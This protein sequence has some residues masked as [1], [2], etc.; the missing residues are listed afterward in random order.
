MLANKLQAAVAGGSQEEEVEWNLNKA[1]LNDSN[2]FDLY[3]AS[4]TVDDVA[5]GAAE[6]GPTGVSFKPDGT[7]MFIIGGGRDAVCQYELTTAWDVSTSIFKKASSI[8]NS[9]PSTEG[10]GQGIFFKPDGTKLYIAGNTTDTIIEYDLSVAWDIGDISYNQA[11]SI[12]S[13]DSA[14]TDLFFKPDGTWM[15]ILGATLPDSV[16]AYQLSTPWDIST[17]VFNHDFPVNSQETAPTGLFFKSDGTQMYVT[18]SSGDDINIYNL[19]TPWVVSGATFQT[20]FSVSSEETAPSGLFISSDGLKMYVVGGAG[21]EVN[22]YTLGS[23]WDVTTAT[24]IQFFSATSPE[25]IATGCCFSSDGTRF[26]MV[27]QSLKSVWEY[28]LDTPWVI[29]GG[30]IELEKISYIGDEDELPE[31]ICFSSDGTQMY[32]LGRQNGRINQYS[33]STAWDINT[34]TYVDYLSIVSYESAA[35]GLYLSQDGHRMYFIGAQRKVFEFYLITAWDITS[36]V[37]TRSKDV[38]G[39]ESTPTA[40]TF[41]NDGTKFYTTGTT[42]DNIYEYN[43][44]DPWNITTASTGS[45]KSAPSNSPQSIFFDKDGVYLYT[46]DEV[47]RVYQYV[48]AGFQDTSLLSSCESVV[49]KSDGTK[50]FILDSVNDYIYQYNLSSAWDPSIYSTTFNQ[51]FNV[52][53]V[54]TSPRGFFISEDGTKMYI[55]GSSNDNVDFYTLSTPWDISTNSQVASFSVSAQATSPR[56]V[57]FKPDGTMMYVV[58]SGSL[59]VYQYS[60]ATAWTSGPSYESSF[61][62]SSEMST[63]VPSGLFIRS[64]GTQMYITDFDKNGSVVKYTLSSPWDITTAAYSDTYTFLRFQLTQIFFKPDGDGFFLSDDRYDRIFSYQIS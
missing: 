25:T 21:D 15:Y 5:V 26:F 7:V 27:G 19:D 4:T 55:T 54:D 36:A 41:N 44:S 45:A 58:D 62:L 31:E 20:T 49:F 35:R 47:P 29:V 42:D 33:L 32:I 64:D 23:S 17:A 39:Q 18:G 24:F 51:S 48:V 34:K 50:M 11:F 3:N 56:E 8:L 63:G 59:A 52:S 53:S 43:M 57:F 40:I 60:L 46:L 10:S 38:S 22:E 37:S 30:G 9:G 1:S 12:A 13:Q 16:Y 2:A 14:F 6:G 28:S 61:S